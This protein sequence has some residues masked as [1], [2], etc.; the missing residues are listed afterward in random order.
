MKKIIG[1]VLLVVGIGLGFYAYNGMQ[2]DKATLKI[3]DIELSAKDKE[4]S[5]QTLIL[6]VLSGVAILGGIGMVSRK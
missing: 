6:F 5:N 4:A 3:G 2:D 1:I